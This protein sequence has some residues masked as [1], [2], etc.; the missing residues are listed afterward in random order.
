MPTARVAGLI[1]DRDS[2]H[3]QVSRSVDAEDLHGGVLDVDAG[4]GG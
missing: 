4:D 1:I 3:G 2:V